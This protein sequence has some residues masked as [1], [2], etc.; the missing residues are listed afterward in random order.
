MVV[1]RFAPAVTVKVP[2]SLASSARAT[3]TGA[4]PAA[5]RGTTARTTVSV[6]EVTRA[7]APRMVTLPWAVPNPRPRMVTAV[8][9]GPRAGVRDAMSGGVATAGIC[10]VTPN[11][12]RSDTV[13]LVPAGIV[14]FHCRAAPLSIRFAGSPGGRMVFG[15]AAPPA[16]AVVVAVRTSE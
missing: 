11:D 16:P 1:A 6:Q 8:P 7:A 5:M 10:G 4:A 9:T 3:T 2:G 12:H 15:S 13:R 14:T